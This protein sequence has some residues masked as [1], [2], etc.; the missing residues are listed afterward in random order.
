MSQTLTL[1]AGM[2]DLGFAVFHMLFWR[3]FGWPER[4]E[5]SGRTN[6]AITQTMNIMLTL[7][8][9]LYGGW[10]IHAGWTGIPAGNHV[11]LCGVAFGLLRSCLQP[12]MFGLQT[13]ASNAF[14]AM[15]LVATAIHAA[16]MS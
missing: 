10:L 9:V 8:F 3:L 13:G 11:L 4:L 16:A 2:L 1:L 7:V 15:A 12:L 14:L 5:A 6:A